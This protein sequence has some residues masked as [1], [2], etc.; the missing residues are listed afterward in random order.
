MRLVEQIGSGITRIRDV[1]NDEGLTPPEFNIDGMFTV[2]LR[3][4]FDFEK[5]VEKLTYN[6]I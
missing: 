2:T 1:M 5:W 4:P 3:R 6:R